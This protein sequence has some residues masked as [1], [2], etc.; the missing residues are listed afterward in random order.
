MSLPPTVASRRNA[1]LRAAALAAIP[2]ILFVLAAGPRVWA[3]DLV[4]FGPRQAAYVAQAEQ[5]APVSWTAAYTD[6]SVS[7]LAI[8]ESVLRTRP[9]PT[10][11][12]IVFRGLLDAAGV[13]LLYV[14]ARRVSGP[15]AGTLAAL[16]YAASPFAWALSRDPAGS[17]GPVL[18]SASLLAAVCLIARP[19]PIRGAI[20]GVTLGLL[21]R[22]LPFGPLIVVLGAVALVV[23][24]AGWLVSGVTVLALIVS[25]GGVL[26]SWV[27]FHVSARPSSIDLTAIQ[28]VLPLLLAIPMG[29]RVR[30]LRWA[31]RIVVGVLA[32]VAAAT[33]AWTM[34]ADS[35]TEWQHSAFINRPPGMHGEGQRRPEAGGSLVWSP[36]YRETAALT[37]AMREAAGRADVNEVVLLRGY[38]PEWLAPFP[39]DA[40]L[41]G[42]PTA[43]LADNVMLPLEREIV[44][45]AASQ[46][47]MPGYAERPIEVRRPSSSIRVLTVSGADTGLELFTLRPRSAADWLAR[48]HTVTSGEFADGTRLLGINAEYRDKRF[49]DVSLYWEL[50]SSVNG[51]PDP[52]GVVVGFAQAP[53]YE[54][55]GGSFPEVSLR[56]KDYLLLMQLR[57]PAPSDPAR[58]GP[59]RLTLLHAK[60]QPIRTSGGADDLE[61]PLH[62]LAR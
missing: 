14:A 41:D 29:M 59:L 55:R 31:T 24:R 5:L 44:F 33:V 12:W 16:L 11:P 6:A 42:V 10:V 21:A 15:L 39:Y 1:R 19:T 37:T 54:R 50:H 49:L 17:I 13:V 25:A 58:A 18:T 36:S 60:L 51:R 35:Q 57:L 45:L 61:L 38:L 23:G 26:F 34:H 7:A 28:P 43:A 30:E 47:E 4:P 20:L 9:S 27:G 40:M 22:S 2:L 3:P 62:W 48:T 46:G 32:T 56:R 53:A 8:F 52:D